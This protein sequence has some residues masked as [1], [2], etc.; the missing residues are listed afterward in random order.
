MRS[1]L[2][3]HDARYPLPVDFIA[4]TM[5]RVNHIAERRAYM[6]GLITITIVSL[7]MIALTFVMLNFFGVKYN[8]TLPIVDTLIHS[9]TVVESIIASPF[10]IMLIIS[11]A[12]LLTLDHLMRRRFAIRHTL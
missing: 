2:T 3:R 7:L 4:D 6:R 9:A 5:L 1:A 10:I 11:T 8:F 12:L